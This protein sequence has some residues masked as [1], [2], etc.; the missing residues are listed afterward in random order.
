MKDRLSIPDLKQPVRELARPDFVRLFETETISEALLRLRRERIGERIIYFYVTDDA[1]RLTGV[2]PTRRLILSDPSRSISAIMLRPVVSVLDSEPFGNALQLIAERRLLAVPV[3]DAEHRLTGVLDVSAFTGNL[4]DLERRRT[5]DEIFQ[6]AGIHIE[7]ERN[8]SSAWI[9]GR[10][11][12]WLLFNLSS[13]I[14]AAFLSQAFDGLLRLVI[15]LAFFVPLILTIAESVAMQSLSL[16][17]SRVQLGTPGLP[18]AGGVLRE[19]RVGLLLGLSSGAI[20]ALIGF[21]WLHN[22]RVA[23]AVAAGITCAGIIGAAFGFLIPR[24]L[25]RWELDP[26][27]ASGPLTLALTDLAALATYFGIS[28]LLLL[29]V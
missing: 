19:L 8:R 7:E 6:L 11:F 2:V 14:A 25:H 1:G 28:M 29:P 13:G 18:P 20:M 5:A 23:G 26:R 12:P 27:I 3:V 9:L 22:V 21:A 17:L 15:A 4:L 10:R 24:L 16:S